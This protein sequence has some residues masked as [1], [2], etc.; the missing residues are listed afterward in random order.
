M[1]PFHR[2]LNFSPF[3]WQERMPEALSQENFKSNTAFASAVFKSIHLN[4]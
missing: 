4:N 3:F 1:Q 2:R